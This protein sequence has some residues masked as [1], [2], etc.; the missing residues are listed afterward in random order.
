MP[1]NVTVT[2]PRWRL[3]KPE[4]MGEENVPV[5]WEDLDNFVTELAV[6]REYADVSQQAQVQVEDCVCAGSCEIALQ[7]ACIVP[8]EREL[9]WVNIFPATYS[10]GRWYRG[11]CFKGQPSQVKVAYRAGLAH[12]LPTFEDAVLRLAHSLMPEVECPSGKDVQHR[13]W[14]RDRA[15]PA[16]MTRERVNCPWGLSN[17]A[18]AAWMFAEHSPYNYGKGGG[19]M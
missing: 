3:V 19:R 6:T 4:L 18:W 14:K 7:S 13:F 1:V 9:S 16:T 2:F 8:V 15:E 10:G 12:A 11:T 5:A 17:G